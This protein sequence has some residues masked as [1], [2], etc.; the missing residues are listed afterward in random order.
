MDKQNIFCSSKFYMSDGDKLHVIIKDL[1]G[2]MPTIELPDEDGVVEDAYPPL[3]EDIKYGAL[4]N[5]YAATDVREIANTGWHV[6]LSSDY[7]N[8]YNLCG[9]VD[10]GAL[11]VCDDN[12]AFWLNIDGIT[13][14]LGLNIRGSG[15]RNSWG[16]FSW[17][18]EYLYAWAIDE[19]DPTAGYVWGINGDD[20]KLFFSNLLITIGP[21]CGASIRLVRPATEAEQLLA[22]GTTCDNYIGND[23]KRYRTVKI[24][25]QVWLADNLVETKYRDGDDIP[26]VTD[27]AAWTALVTGAMCYYDN[28]INNA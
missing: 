14:E 19:S 10:E 17:I 25:T 28:D 7:V 15:F 22:D 11:K 8:L 23:L 13:N 26:E 4:Y 2:T 5:W 21:F 16:T 1:V 12:T 27:N 3:P 6:P 20:T 18:K 24:G 9:A